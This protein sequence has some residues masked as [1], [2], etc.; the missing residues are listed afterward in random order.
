MPVITATELARHTRQILDRVARGGETV[1]IARNHTEVAR[2]VPTVATQTAAEALAGLP[3][4]LTA[5]QG[6]RWLRDSREGG[7]GDE[8]RDPWA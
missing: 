6:E 5:E 3:T 8:V 7:F 2:L 1:V 4:G